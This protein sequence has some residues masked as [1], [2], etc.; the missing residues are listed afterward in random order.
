MITL[1][2]DELAFRPQ[3]LP[4]GDWILFTVT[5]SLGGSRWDMADI[6]VESVGTGERRGAASRGQ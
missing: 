5:R 4:G 3:R 2:S 1:K 6:V